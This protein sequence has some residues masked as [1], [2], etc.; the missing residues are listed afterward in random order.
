MSITGYL[1]LSRR[2]GQKIV[3]GKGDEQIVIT[4]GETSEMGTKLLISAP[5][6]TPVNRM[7]IA[8]KKGLY[9]PREV[10]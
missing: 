8:I 5:V 1:A 9:Q 7:E 4:M 6:K 2:T 3:I 10:I